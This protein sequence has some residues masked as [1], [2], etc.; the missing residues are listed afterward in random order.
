MFY[1]FRKQSWGQGFATA[2]TEWLLNFMRNKYATAAI[3]AEVV[4][5]NAASEKI[6]QN[7]GFDFNS[8]ADE[9]ERDGINMKIRNY[10]LI[11]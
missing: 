3:L 10:A 4:A 7:F 2:A 9:F 1:H 6:L 8:E 11:L 5:D